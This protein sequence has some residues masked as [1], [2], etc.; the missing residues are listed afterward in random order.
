[1]K[2]VLILI[3][4]ALLTACGG[5]SS[6][7]GDSNS[8]RIINGITAEA[9]QVVEIQLSRGGADSGRC[10]GTVIGPG[11]VLTAGHCVHQGEDSIKINSGGRL[12]EALSVVRHPGYFEDPALGAI[13]NDAAIIN[14]GDLGVPILPLSAVERV[15]AGD[16]VTVYGFGLDENGN[17]GV[18]RGTA[19][20]IQT[21]TPNHFFSV[22]FSSDRGEPCIGDSGGPLIA[23]FVDESG[24]AQSVLAGLVS[25]GT[26]ADCSPGDTTIFTNLTNPGIL[27]FIR[28]AVPAAVVR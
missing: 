21:A 9:P 19:M 16:D 13:F 11:A 20:T 1:M 5:S 17:F 3:L 27:G 28:N 8:S 23:S 12:Y 6:E 22:P 2:K 18:L 25:S 24:S 14:T 15:N 4:L 26:K 7:G 10:S